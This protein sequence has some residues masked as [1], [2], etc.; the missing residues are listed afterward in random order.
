MDM[1]DM[2]NFVFSENEKKEHPVKH[3]SGDCY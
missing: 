1:K 3:A 2:V